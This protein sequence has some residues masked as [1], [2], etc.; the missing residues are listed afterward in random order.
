MGLDRL[1][2]RVIALPTS[3]LN[4]LLGAPEQARAVTAEAHRLGTQVWDLVGRA[5][6]ALDRVEL[7]LDEVA[8]LLTAVA[9]L[10]D[11]A[12]VV[13]TAASGVV[14]DG[15]QA[16]GELEAQAHRVQRLLDLYEPEIFAPASST[17]IVDPS[18]RTPFNARPTVWWQAV[19]EPARHDSHSPQ[20]A[21]LMTTRSPTF[22]AVTSDPVARTI[23]TPS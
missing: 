7:L 19:T 23:P 18:A 9:V 21:W 12:D 22:A 14:T 11:E 13:V 16:V 15:A 8:A 3:T 10:R 4:G 6:A 17:M 20:N 1:A 2:W 5:Q